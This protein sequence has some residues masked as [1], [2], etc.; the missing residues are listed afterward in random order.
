MGLRGDII[1]KLR[2]KQLDG[3]LPGTASKAISVGASTPIDE[4]SRLKSG[5]ERIRLEPL[6]GSIEWEL[7]SFL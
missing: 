6:Q 4:N 3:R 2:S 5:G 1:G 7:R